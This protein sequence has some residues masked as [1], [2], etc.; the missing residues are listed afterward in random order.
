MYMIFNKLWEEVIKFHNKAYNNLI[1]CRCL[2]RGKTC[3][4]CK[5]W[6][7]KSY[8]INKNWSY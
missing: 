8:Q 2:W 3:K 1:I 4:T 5:D 6:N 7:F